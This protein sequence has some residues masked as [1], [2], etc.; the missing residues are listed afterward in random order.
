MKRLLVILGIVF[1]LVMGTTVVYAADSGAQDMYRL[2]NKNSGEHFY[3]ASQFEAQTLVNQGWASEGVGFV[4]P[5]KSNTPVYRL[6]NQNSGDHHYTTSS[7]EKDSLVK[8]GWSYEGIGWYSSDAKTVKL[9]RA[10]N[11][12]AK[13]G[14]HNYTTNPAEEANLVSM[15]WRDEGIAWYAIGFGTHDRGVLTPETVAQNSTPSQPSTGDSGWGYAAPG[16][17]Y[18]NKRSGIMW[19]EVKNPE[20]Y[21]YMTEAEAYSRG[22]RPPKKVSASVA[23]YA[24]W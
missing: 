5:K 7:F 19:H 24:R 20:N 10:Y 21:D 18:V 4:A 1:G 17:C 2:Y 6:Y 9:L 13:A 12:N 16:Y 23:Q 22:H 3:T 15:G 11:P 14:S 8:V